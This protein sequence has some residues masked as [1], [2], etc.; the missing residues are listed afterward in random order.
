LSVRDH[1]PGVPDAEL[2]KLFRPFFRGAN[3]ARAEG[4]GLGLAIVERIARAHGGYVSA[5]NA[6]GGGLRVTLYLPLIA[7]AAG[8]ATLKG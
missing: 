5:A 4:H 1:G 7:A 6:E 2:P 3:A 8:A